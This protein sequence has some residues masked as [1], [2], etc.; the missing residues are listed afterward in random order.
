MQCD[1]ANGEVQNLYKNN[2]IYIQ[3]ICEKK[4]FYRDSTSERERAFNKG[5]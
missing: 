1:N 3:K 4:M 2:L 5:Q